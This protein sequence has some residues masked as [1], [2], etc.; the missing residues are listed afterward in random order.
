MKIAY[1][2]PH[3]VPDILPE[4]MQ[5]LQTVDAMGKCGAEVLLVTPQSTKNAEEVLGRALNANVHPIALKDLRRSKWYP[6]N[7][8]KAFYWLATYWVYK[9]RKQFDT[10]L[11]RNLKLAEHLLK[12][13]PKLPIFFETHELFAKVFTEENSPLSLK[14]SKK[15]AKLEKR[16]SFVYQRAKGVIALTPF[17]MDD[18]K[19]YYAIKD[20]KFVIAPDGVD[21]ELA[22]QALVLP[23]VRNEVP[24]ILYL[25]S[26]HPWKGVDLIIKAMPTIDKS[27]LWIAGGE[28]GR[29]NELKALSQ[30]LGVAERIRFLGKI[31]PKERFKLIHQTDICVLPLSDT[32]IAS[33][34][35]SPLKLFEYLAMGKIVVVP[36]VKSMTS[37]VNNMS[38]ALTFSLNNHLNLASVINLAT[39]DS[40]D[41]ATV[42]ANA[43]AIGFNYSWLVRANNIL[44]FMKS[45]LNENR[46]N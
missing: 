7:S 44:G 23:S 41:K 29:I 17:L 37:I 35:T 42:S 22:E 40:F 16:E 6:S 45:V 21:L 25:G 34:Y 28:Q 20:N 31:K 36:D 9:N 3:P 30:E 8:N 38:N 46:K 14:N 39:K 4:T 2:D 27:L 1:I 43:K 10:I 32:S 33:L 24:I 5:I 15:L 26:L 13:F 18:I 11:V 12:I 19:S